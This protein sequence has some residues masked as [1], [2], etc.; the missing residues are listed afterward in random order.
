M[1]IVK[2]MVKEKRNNQSETKRNQSGK[3]TKKDQ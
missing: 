3:E 2:R 1:Q